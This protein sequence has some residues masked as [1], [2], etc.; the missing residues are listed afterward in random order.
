M[1]NSLLFPSSEFQ[2]QAF[3]QG[4]KNIFSN[5]QIDVFFEK[6][7]DIKR[8]IVIMDGQG[9]LNEQAIKSAL[10]LT[11]IVLLNFNC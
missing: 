7:F 5:G 1:L 3:E 6:S 8:K 10:K 9:N 4:D 2:H 11:N